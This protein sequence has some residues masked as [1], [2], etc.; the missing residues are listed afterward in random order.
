MLLCTCVCIYKRGCGGDF[1]IRGEHRLFLICPCVS[2]RGIKAIFTSHLQS[3]RQLNPISTR[4]TQMTTGEFLPRG[5]LNANHTKHRH[6]SGLP[7]PSAV[8]KSDTSC[9]C[10]GTKKKKVLPDRMGLSGRHKQ[11]GGPIANLYSF[12]KR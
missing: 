7:V 12:E 5:G 9:T 8:I 4:Q 10:E 2:R 3:N 11:E 6:Q 1:C